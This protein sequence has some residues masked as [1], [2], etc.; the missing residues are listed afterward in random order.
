[1]YRIYLSIGLLICLVKTPLVFA[2]RTEFKIGFS[3]CVSEDSWRVA[4]EKEM[5]IEVSF[6]PRMSMIKRDA[7]GDS[8]QQIKDVEDML[9]EG[10]DL[11]I[12]SPNESQPL[13]GIVEK[14]FEAG[15]PVIV[16]DRKINS[17]KWTAYVGAD[18]YEIGRQAG[19]YT[20]NTLKAEGTVI[21]ILGL[22]GSSPAI[23]RHRGFMEEVRKHSGI[24]IIGSAPGNWTWQGGKTVMES[25]LKNGMKPM[26]V[27]CHND[28]MASGAYEAIIQQNKIKDFYLIGID[29]LAGEQGGI[30]YVI[31]KKLDATFLYPTGGD[32]A[33]GVAWKILNKLPYEKI[34]ALQS[35]LIDS[36]NASTIKM[37]NGLLAS[38]QDKI[39]RQREIVGKYRTQIS[40]LRL[41]SIVF[42]LF[43]AI[44]LVL[45]LLVIRAYRGKQKANLVLESQKLEFEKQNKKLQKIT[46][47]LEIATTQKLR[48]FTNISH[49]FRTPLT[50]LIGPLETMI[51]DKNIPEKIRVQLDMMYRNALRLLR[52]IN[53]LMDFRKL[54]NTKMLLQSGNYDIIKFLSEVKTNFDLLAEKQNVM[55]KF[56]SSA[57]MLNV[58]FDRDKLDKIMF[59]LLSNAFKFTP[60]GGKV[61]IEIFTSEK[62]IAGVQREA[63]EIIIADNG[64]GMSEEHLRKI[65][66]RFYQVEQQ[67]QGNFFPGTGLGLSLSKGLI[68]LHSGAIEVISKKGEGTAFHVFLPLGNEHLKENEII[69]DA[70]DYDRPGRQI[71]TISEEFYYTPQISESLADEPDQKTSRSDKHNLILIVEDNED[72][73]KYMKTSLSH[74]YEIGVARNGVEAWEIVRKD[75]PDL[76]IS[77]VMMPMMD[78][79]E[80]TRNIKTDM[81][82]CHI[83]VILLTAKVSVE[84]KLDGLEAGADSYIPKPFNEKH[85]QLRVKKLIEL[86][87]KLNEHYRDHH[88]FE[89]LESPIGRLDKRFLDR[90]ASFIMDNILSQEFGVEELSKEIGISRVHLYRKIK[91][92]TGLSVSEYIRSV[93]LNKAKALMQNGGMTVSEIAYAS[94]F[95]SPS[96][97]TKCF[98]NQY[99]MSPS[100]YLNSINTS[101]QS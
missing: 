92:L 2:Q 26:L 32:I 82:T 60:E 36:T 75:L 40:N 90:S 96:Y 43:S 15:I 99:E 64:R 56:Q 39:E 59:N 100:D 72:L 97:F 20:V 1:M 12:I 63:V 34:N 78:G 79:L 4:M 33:I 61:T 55:F 101:G 95:T 83:P 19:L 87:K 3:Q 45:I 14:T 18:N 16:V 24:K 51:I 50:L 25:M 84:N 52:L 5:D 62:M 47:Q 57:A 13:T 77:D 66:E 21:E 8:Q 48:F 89:N 17:E 69:K 46:E 58:W 71:D 70:S 53:Q 28:F 86:R 93:K 68:E 80:L 44:V 9:K 30:Q 85:L 11:L 41:L 67:R 76:V 54:E 73:L 23:E 27:Y 35:L 29:G 38:M 94:G 22:E 10:I 98:K 74:K 88:S 37:Q 42:S 6:Y 49:E 65:F 91:Q 7:G 31:D 81:K